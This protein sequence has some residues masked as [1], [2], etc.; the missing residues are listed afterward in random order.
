MGKF[1]SRDSTGTPVAWGDI[2]GKPST[3]D[4]NPHDN[5]A[6]STAYAPIANPTFTG[7]VTIASELRITSPGNGIF[8]SLLDVSS[9]KLEAG[10]TAGYRSAVEIYGGSSSPTNTIKLLTASSERV[11]VNNN[12]LSVFGSTSIQK[13]DGAS[14]IIQILT[15][16]G[17][18]NN[19][20]FAT[21][22]MT[23]DFLFVSN[24]NG[25]GTVKNIHFGVGGGDTI[26][27]SA[28]MTILA[29]GNVGIGTTSPAEKLH[30][31]GNGLFTGDVICYG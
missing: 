4:P 26:A 7:T 13:A 24:K 28:K 9:Q 8:G 22:N 5:A 11:R 18:A 12:G 15:N 31:S 20:Y 1:A 23:D 6:H 3:F 14:S 2:T 25:T 21:Y 27:T 29:N 17:G 10:S 19:E 16:D 30:V